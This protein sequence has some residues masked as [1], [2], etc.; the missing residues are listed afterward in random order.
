MVRDR[1]AVIVA[2]ILLF[3][4]GGVWMPYF[5][6]YLASLG[7]RGTEIGLLM[8]LQPALRWGSAIVWA[9][10]A[11]RWRVRHR[12]LLVAGCGG[13]LCYVPLLFARR[14]EAMV[15]VTGLI[16]LLHAPLIP[17]VDATVMD[18]LARLGRDYGRLRMWGSLSFV[19]G[20]L[21]SAPLIRWFSPSVVP[22]LLLIA[23]WGL[24]P[25]LTT[26]PREQ[27]GRREHFRAP[28]ALV[29][30]PLAAFLATAFLIQLS[31]GAW[32]GFYAVHTAAL[33]FSDMIPG[34]TW[35]LAVTAEVAMLFWGRQIVTRF[36]PVNLILVA[37]AVTVVRWSLTAVVR[38]E[39][40]VVGLQLGHAFTFSAFHLAALL[41]LSRLVPAESSTSGQ[42][43]YG[44]IGFGLGGS[45]GLYLAGRLVDRFG[46]S[47]V[48]AFEAV[49]A[50]LGFVP[51]F[52]L[53]RLLQHPQ[54]QQRDAEEI[55]ESTRS[56]RRERVEQT[57]NR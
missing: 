45:S 30:P 4:G 28:W 31:C 46:T 49:I 29:S 33:G 34:L 8:G 9:Y 14:F 54:R 13:A 43:L 3:W 41:L 17:M 15:A 39:A 5:P 26:L 57:S 56:S 16:A 42:A 44:T 22:V 48:F 52:V 2:Y 47:G 20:A 19:L 51:A 1:R 55:R 12:M 37:L 53:W 35:A 40:I 18:H 50:A 24:V 38:N 32:G 6:L 23:A 27:M 21:V 11:D 25:P 36:P 10:A 7:Y